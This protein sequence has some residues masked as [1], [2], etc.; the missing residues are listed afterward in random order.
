MSASLELRLPDAIG[1]S[2]DLPS[3]PGVIVEILRLSKDENAG[4][5]DFARIISGDPALAARLIKLSNSSMFAAGSDVT[6]LERA[7]VLLGLK[8]VQLMALSFSLTE[9]GPEPSAEGRFSLKEYWARCLITAVSGRALSKRLKHHLDDEAFLCGL[10]SQLGQL[11]ILQSMPKEYGSVLERSQGSWPTRELESEVLGFDRSQVG[12]ALLQE[13]GLPSPVCLSIAFSNRPDE[14][15]SDAGGDVRRL[16]N[17]LHAAELT[18]NLLRDE[19]KGEALAALRGVAE[20]AGLSESELDSVLDELDGDLTEMAELLDVD[21][22]PGA[23]HAE[24]MDDARQQVMRISLGTAADLHQAERRADNLASENRALA[25]KA[26]K[27]DLTGIPNRAGFDEILAGEIE[28]LIKKSRPNALGLLMLDADHFKQFNDTHGHR[29]GDEV[30]RTL[31]RILAT[32]TRGD[33]VPARY[34]GEEFAVIAPGTTPEGLGI[35]AERLR[36][37][38]EA[39]IID[40][41]GTQLQ[42][43]V[44]IGG[45]SM[46]TASGQDAAARLIEAADQNLYEAKHAGRNR[47]VVVD[48]PVTAD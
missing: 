17:L 19:S 4:L 33:D 20:L 13:W 12:A 21:L 5:D 43:T 15:P 40:H 24:I 31:G 39:E 35:L 14:L 36:Q 6:T 23:S 29:A 34:G 42:V 11:A 38:I 1:K 48:E 10:L 8:T 47:C 37:T 25:E 28:A 18:A 46:V 44:S 32:V 27:D 26:S 16:A 41:E 9:N 7:C 45:A 22:D 3:P 30:L 2:E